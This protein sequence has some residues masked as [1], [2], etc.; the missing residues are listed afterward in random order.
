MHKFAFA[1]SGLDYRGSADIDG[2]LWSGGQGDFRISE[3]AGYI[4]AVTTEPAPNTSDAIDHH[5]FILEESR[6]SLALDLVSR[7][8]NDN[9]PEEIG[10]PNERL[11]GVRFLGDRA[12]AVTFEQIDPL[13]VIDLADPLNPRIAG[14]LEVTGFSDFL[15]PVSKDL[16]LGLGRGDTGGI[17]LELFDISD[18]ANPL[19]VGL[20]LLGGSGTYSEARYDRHAFTYQADVGT[21][22]RFIIP[23]D[24]YATD[25][26]YKLQASGLYFYE[27]L[28]KE[29]PDLASLSRVGSLPVDTA[30]TG[31]PWFA[32]SRNRSILHDD[33]VFYVRDEDVWSTFWIAPGVVNGPF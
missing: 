11:Y 3:Y 28:N 31:Q 19:S 30:T 33:T 12:Y 29:T 14:D 13:Y 4:R 8:P 18:I 20:D 1:N 27:I 23:A 21:T 25:G 5:L 6:T 17:K 7:L 22:D 32:A 26:S 15:H 16:L 10:K 9:Q 2:F 24:L